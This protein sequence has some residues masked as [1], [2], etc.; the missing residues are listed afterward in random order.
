MEVKKLRGQLIQDKEKRQEKREQDAWKRMKE[1]I[2]CYKTVM[3]KSEL[4][5][6][7]S[8][9]IKNNLNVA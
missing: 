8:T 9:N 7:A 1:E 4:E 5:I 6:L 2:I 3:Y